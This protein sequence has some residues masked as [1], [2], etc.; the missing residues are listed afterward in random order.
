MSFAKGAIFGMLTGAI[1]GV[2]NSEDI[3][4]MFRTGKKEM[5][6]LKRKYA[7]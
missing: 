4:N 7:C 1:I 2:M 5:K 3:M 6:K